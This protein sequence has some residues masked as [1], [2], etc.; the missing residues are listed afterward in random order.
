MN[1]SRTS[2]GAVLF[3]IDEYY[4]VSDQPVVFIL[5]KDYHEHLIDGDDDGVLV[6]SSKGV[7]GREDIGYINRYIIG[8]D[9]LHKALVSYGLI[10]EQIPKI[11]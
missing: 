4:M 9:E 11:P 5:D 1:A 2:D 7:K 3:T 6:V 10:P 8:A